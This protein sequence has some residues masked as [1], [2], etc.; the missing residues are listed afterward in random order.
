MYCADLADAYVMQDEY[1]LVDYVNKML[2]AM[3]KAE[4]KAKGIPK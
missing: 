3:A 1:K 4:A 2:R